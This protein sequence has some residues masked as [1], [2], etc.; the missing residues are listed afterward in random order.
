MRRYALV[1]LRNLLIASLI[2][3]FGALIV[4]DVD[5][6]SFGS[7]AP[8][9]V[10]GIV[11]VVV[12]GCAVLAYA[13][14]L[15]RQQSQQQ[16][17]WKR[18]E[19]DITARQT[20]ADAQ[21]RKAEDEI[22]EARKSATALAEKAQQEASEA[23]NREAMY[24]QALM[25]RARGFP[26]LSAMIAKIDKVDDEDL[27]FQLK[28]KTSPA[29]KAAEAVA[30]ETARRR[31]AEREVRIARSIVEYYESLAPFLVDLKDEEFGDG[32]AEDE[33]DRRPFTPSEREDPL[34]NYLT[35]EEY[36]NLSEGERNQLA[37][38]RFWQR[39]KSRQQ[40]GRLYERYVG[41]LYES[42]GYDV[43]YVGI[44]KGFEDL[45]R[46]LICSKGDEIVVIQCKMWSKFKTIF[47]NHIFQF[48]GT[49][50]EYRDKNPDKEVRA[51]FYTT[52]MVSDLARRFAN[53]LGIELVENHEF[54]KQYPSI[55]CNIARATKEKIYH[56]PFD[57]QYDKT[58][59]EPARGEFYCRTV[60]EAEEA[61][62]RR[63]FRYHGLQRDAE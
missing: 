11:L 50:F 51:F 43:D 63:A 24:R 16:E 3:L 61:G 35:I 53:E 41:F 27:E 40:I 55:K 22:R 42:D 28:Y 8:G 39:P 13:Q 12:L 9:W 46:D 1:F 52:T 29:P 26:S 10:A 62:Y 44:F 37:L 6:A 38:D 54:D 31:D 34:T 32:A 25:E 5:A 36:R 58:K 15:S 2:G 60:A 30:R 14:Q 17:G 57:Q 56:L 19:A 21:Y 59:V 7:L 4:T 23:K 48:F 33:L 49:V 45:G 20:A 18:R 47:E